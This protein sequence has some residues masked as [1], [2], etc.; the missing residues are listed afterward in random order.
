MQNIKLSRTLIK[1]IGKT[2]HIRSENANQ[3]KTDETISPNL[4]KTTHQPTD[5]KRQKTDHKLHAQNTTEPP[6]FTPRNA[7]SNT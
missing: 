2:T 7:Q 3:S 4:I 5:P 6:K 1:S